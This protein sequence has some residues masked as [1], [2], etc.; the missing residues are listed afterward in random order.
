VTGTTC[1]RD[2][3]SSV[4]LLRGVPLPELNKT[5]F[6]LPADVLGFT[7]SCVILRRKLLK[8]RNRD[9]LEDQA[10]AGPKMNFC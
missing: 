9:L 5:E 1:E 3:C 2:C 4:F 6:M 8:T 7:Y 10:V